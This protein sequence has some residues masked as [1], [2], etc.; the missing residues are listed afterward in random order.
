MTIVTATARAAVLAVNGEEN[1]PFVA[2]DNIGATGTLTSTT[3]LTDGAAANAFTGTTYDYWLPDVPVGGI[4]ALQSQ[5]TSQTFSFAAIAAHNLA[6]YGAT[7]RVQNSADG[8]TWADAGAGAVTPTDNG[9]I[10]WRM[11]KSGNSQPYWRFYITGLDEDDPIYIG[12]AFL[13]NDLVMPR[14]FYQGYAPVITPTDV[15]IANNISDGGQFLGSSFVAN[16]SSLDANF[17][18]VSP[19]FIRGDDFKGF[20]RHFNKAKPFWFGWRPDKYVADLHYCWRSGN[21]LRPTNSGPH[22]LMDFGFSASVH[23]ADDQ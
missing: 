18:H 2:Y 20:M 15:R 21:A 1:N 6:D 17:A 10:A 8:T 16:G 7:I 9:P 23:E 14:R 11:V 13:G 12:V 19:T 22:E 4:A 5:V 3:T